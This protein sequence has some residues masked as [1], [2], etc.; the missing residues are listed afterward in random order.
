MIDTNRNFN[1]SICLIL[2]ITCIYFLYSLQ[3]QSHKKSLLIAVS[4]LSKNKTNHNL[5]IDNI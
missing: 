4:I 2:I 1:Y 5:D 3:N